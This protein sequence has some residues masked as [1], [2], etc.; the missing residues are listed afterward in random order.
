MNELPAGARRIAFFGGS[1]DPPHLGHLTIARAA[2]DALDLDAVLF[3]PVGAQPLKPKGS[4]APFDD[5]VAMT[6]LAIRGDAAFSVSL[7]DAPSSSSQPNYTVDTLLRLRGALPDGGALF[8]LMGADSFLSLRKWRRAV[9]VP[10]AAQLIVASRPGLRLDDLSAGLPQG[11]TIDAADADCAEGG[12]ANEMRCFRLRNPAGETAGFY[13]L[14][15]L[16]VEISATEIRKT[17]RSGAAGGLLPE[18]VC[19][20]IREHRLYQ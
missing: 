2:R 14:P 15:G 13:L 4:T 12:S 3:A 6:E 5:R 17:I 7:A 11:V 18:A 9:E 16:F 1:F 20:Y 19:A 10:F 8:C